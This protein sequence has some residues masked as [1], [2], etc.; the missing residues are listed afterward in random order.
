[1]T[2]KIF[3]LE[4]EWHSNDLRNQSTVETYLRFLKETFGIEYLFR[5]V[6][7]RESFFKYLEQLGRYSKGRYKD[8]SIIY[9]AFHGDKKELFLDGTDSVEINELTKIK[10]TPLKSRIIHFG[11]C[12][13]LKMSFADL[14]EFWED[15]KAN[16]VSG[17]SKNI[18]FM[19]ASLFD[20]AYLYKL[21]TMPQKGRV[22]NHINKKFKRL[23]NDL[24]FVYI[25]KH[26]PK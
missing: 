10:H 24:G 8:Y 21:S 22:F 26:N 20:I 17:F 18:D 2:T 3:C 7:S 5:K 16:A 13:T 14:E 19:E 25:D 23:S 6:N 9:F 15:S 11:S 4:G 12:R 1:M